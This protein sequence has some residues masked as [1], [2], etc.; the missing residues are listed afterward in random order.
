MIADRQPGPDHEPIYEKAIGADQE[1]R[2][3]RCSYG[4]PDTAGGPRRYDIGSK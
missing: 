3:L 2:S 1:E 4:L